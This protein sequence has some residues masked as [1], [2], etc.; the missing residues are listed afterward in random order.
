MTLQQH[1]ARRGRLSELSRAVGVSHSTVLRWI[2]S[3]V[4]AERVRAVSAAT[5]IPPHQLRP[6]LFDAPATTAATK[7]A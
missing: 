2:E 1:I 5:G 3:R 4:P 7:V 6:D